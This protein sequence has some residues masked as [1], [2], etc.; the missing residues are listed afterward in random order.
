MKRR[1][2][3]LAALAALAAILS[4][5]GG[6][7]TPGGS[8]GTETPKP[9]ED[10][11]ARIKRE[12][13]IRWG[14][15]ASGGAPFVYGD[16][17]DPNK[18]IGFEVDMMDKIAPHLGVKHERVQAQWDGLL[19]DLKNKRSDIVI[20]GIEINDTRLKTNS[21]SQPYYTYEQQLS[22]RAEDKDKFKSLNDLK[23]KKIG[24]LSGTES[25]NVLRR[26]GFKDEQIVG[27]DDS[28]TPYENLN[29]KRVD[30]VVAEWMI[31]DFYAGPKGMVKGIYNVPETF[32]PGKYGIALRK[33]PESE[34]LLKEIDRVLKLMK[35]NGE[36]AAIY[37]RWNIWNDKQKELGISDK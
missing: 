26:M 4:G 18:V 35:E 7:S 13:V 37:K 16:P 29:L 5:C 22:V 27:H 32:S 36:L 1:A 24:I 34:A 15:D 30:G 28:K 9:G 21:F 12:G 33:E 10:T 11:L 8:T 19:T 23:D 6:G 3:A 2:F 31:A 14:A 20:N 17:N 25:G